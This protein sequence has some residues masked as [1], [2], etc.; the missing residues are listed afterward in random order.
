MEEKTKMEQLALRVCKKIYP[1]GDDHFAKKTKSGNWELKYTND[2]PLQHGTGGGCVVPQSVIE[3]IG[4]T[5]S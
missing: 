1:H 5:L 4:S 3:I 2:Y